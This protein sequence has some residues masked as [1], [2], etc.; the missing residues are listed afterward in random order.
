MKRG[1]E[2]NHIRKQEAGTQDTHD[3]GL[4]ISHLILTSCLMNCCIISV[5]HLQAVTLLSSSRS[6]KNLLFTL[7]TLCYNERICLIHYST[8]QK[9][10]STFEPLKLPQRKHKYA[11]RV[12]R[13]GA[14]KY[15][16]IV[17]PSNIQ[18]QMRLKWS[19]FRALHRA[20]ACDQ[21]G[22][23]CTHFLRVCE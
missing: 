15:F 17:A 16:F 5:L 6:H 20:L 23:I 19:H 12:S 2:T 22:H 21:N 18:S 1:Q 7:S 13:T 10:V 9:H 3:R 14:P 4:S 8:L 11:D